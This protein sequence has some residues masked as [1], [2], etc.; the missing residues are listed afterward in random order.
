[1]A[2]ALNLV[3]VIVILICSG[4]LFVTMILSGLTYTKVTSDFCDTSLT[5]N[6][7][8]FESITTMATLAPTCDQGCTVQDVSV[9]SNRA[10]INFF[11]LYY[12]VGSV[13]S[14]WNDRYNNYT[15]LSYNQGPIN[16]MEQNLCNLTALTNTTYSVFQYIPPNF[17]RVVTT[18]PE[19]NINTYA[20]CT[21]ISLTGAAYAQLIQGKT[22]KGTVTLYGRSYYA[23][24]APVFDALT[25]ALIGALYTGVQV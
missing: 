12:M 6:S 8:S 15:L 1:M 7:C 16:E 20:I 11:M 3:S 10:S 22:Y 5:V 2:D 13:R 18:L 9:S 25:K 24:Y 14:V 4:L 17:E 21:D 23:I 19:Q